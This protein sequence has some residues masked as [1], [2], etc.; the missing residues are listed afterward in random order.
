MIR[1]LNGAQMRRSLSA[2]V[3]VLILTLGVAAPASAGPLD[4]LFGWGNSSEDEAVPANATVEIPETAQVPD[5][6]IEDDGMLRVYLKSLGGPEQLHITMA[7]AYTVENDAGFRF[8][9][10]TRIALSAAEGSVYMAVGGLTVNMGSSV[11]FTR[12]S[13]ADG[14]EN[15]L[16]IDE[17]EKDTL[18]CGD[19]TVSVDGEGGLRPVL[20]IQMEDYLYG[21]VAYEMSDSFPL[22]ALKAQAVA[23]R[24]YAMQRKWNAGTKDYDVVDTTSDQVFKGYSAEYVNVIEAVDATRGVV[25]VYNGSFATCYYTASNGG[26]T[27]LA[28]QIWGSASDDGYLAMQEDP[29]DLENPSSLCSELTVSPQCE[30]SSTLK[31][32]LEEGLGDV[33]AQAGFADGEWQFD[34]IESIQPVNPRFEG[35]LMYDGLEFSI[36]VQ[37]LASALATPTPTATP[38]P[39]PASASPSAGASISPSPTQTLPLLTATPES[40]PSETPEATPEWILS[41]EVYKVTLSVYDQIKDGL[42][43]GLN[44]SDYELISVETATDDTGAIQSFTLMMR[45]FGHGVGMSQRG[46]QWMAGEYGKTWLDI[47]HF[48]YPGMS[49]ERIEWPEAALTALADLPDSVGAARPMPTPTPSPAP[50]PALEEGEYYASVTL[51]TKSSSLNVRQEPSTSARIVDQ[52]SN[53]RRVIVSGDAD[54][55]GWVPIHTAEISGYVKL[56]YLTKE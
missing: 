2:L 33:M 11:T 53:G 41:E 29:Y 7:G 45:R 9:R 56:E 47:L 49:I 18:Y 36:R 46:A 37:V 54:A 48:Y 16:Y 6:Q 5:S 51:E 14:E 42:S 55:E 26:Q 38:E 15:G 44:G 39:T 35:S 28:S 22:E 25:G 34:A 8:D 20:K 17:T 43:L 3:L 13:V 10:D 21:V 52:L 31:A 1:R 12:H 24:T 19:L 40:T 30:G 4:W 32:M 27:A 50:L 23:A